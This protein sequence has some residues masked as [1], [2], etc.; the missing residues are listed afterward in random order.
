[1][2]IAEGSVQI[3]FTLYFLLISQ[4][5]IPFLWFIACLNTVTA[6][7]SFFIVESPRY[8]YSTQ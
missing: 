7:L 5:A 2:I 3:I 4:N 6:A 8:L 1:L